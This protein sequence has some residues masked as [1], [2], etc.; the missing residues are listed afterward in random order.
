LFLILI[1]DLPSRLLI[2][3]RLYADDNKIISQIASEEDSKSL[4]KDIDTLDEWS[5]EWSL[6]LNFEKCK[7]MHFGKQNKQYGYNMKDNGIS[8]KLEVSS[9]EKD[10][11]VLISSDLKWEKQ[12][13]SAAGKANSKLALLD[14][15]FTYQEK[16]LM[17]TLYCTYVRPHL[18]LAIQAWCPYLSKDVK[19]LENVQKRATKLIPEI[20][21]LKYAERLIALGMTT[22]EERRLRGDLIQQFKI[23]K[24]YD[25]VMFGN[26]IVSNQSAPIEGPAYNIRHKQRINQEIVPHCIA[27]EHFF[28]NR[29][30]LAWN[31]LP[32]N[33]INSKSIY[34]FKANLQSIDIG[35]F[36]EEKKKI[37]KCF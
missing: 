17:R 5:E 24:G 21:H 20:R 11:G 25:P 8:R 35:A 30:A 14:R 33:V 3:C 1:N 36:L 12:V 28:T 29:V 32:E 18:E 23:F 4:Q 22:L 6:G 26:S 27:R 19:E 34:S 7:I 2:E 15:T 10:I 37:K 13:R 9:V 31:K 16:N